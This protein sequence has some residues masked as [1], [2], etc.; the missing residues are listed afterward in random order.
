MPGDDLKAILTRFVAEVWN[1]G[2]LD[3]VE[4][5]IAP[6]YIRHDPGLPMEVR[7]PDGVRQVVGMYRTAFPDLHLELEDLLV[8]GDR[9]ALRLTGSGTHRGPLPGVPP[10]GRPVTVWAMEIHRFERGKIVEQWVLIDNLRLLQQIAVVPA[11]DGAGT[12]A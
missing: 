8:E 11:P 5:F 12:T 4:Q 9:L 3:A 7:G 1:G 10:T 2:Q 6:S